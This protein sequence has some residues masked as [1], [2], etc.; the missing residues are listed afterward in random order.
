MAL[1]VLQATGA[2]WLLSSRST[3]CTRATQVPTMQF[4]LL[5]PN[6]WTAP[7][8]SKSLHSLHPARHDELLRVR[9]INRDGATREYEITPTRLSQEFGLQPRYLRNLRSP[10]QQFSSIVVKPDF[11]LF[12]LE[13][14]KGY[15]SNERLILLEDGHPAIKVVERSVVDILQSQQVLE[16][17]QGIGG[18]FELAVL[19]AVLDETCGFFEQSWLRW[20]R[21][22]SQELEHMHHMEDKGVEHSRSDILARLLP[23]EN[24][25]RKLRIRAQRVNDILKSLI[26]NDEDLEMLCLSLQQ[27]HNSRGDGN[28]LVINH[29]EVELLLENFSSRLDNLDDQLG[30]LS[31]RIASS[32]ELLNLSLANERNQILRLELRMAMASLSFAL[33]GAVA[34]FWGMNLDTGLEATAGLAWGVMG[35]TTLAAGS[36]FW[37]LSGAA[38]RVKRTQ[39]RK[40]VKQEALKHV[41]SHMDHIHYALRSDPTLIQRWL[42]NPKICEEDITKMLT[43]SKVIDGSEAEAAKVLLETLDTSRDGVLQLQELK[44]V[45]GSR[46]IC[47]CGLSRQ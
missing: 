33:C 31:G 6:S 26:S 46:G 28:T 30:D 11:F 2:R 35:S 36:L 27:T 15:C 9:E 4:A 3:V 1:R 29:D 12:R 37:V 44:M 23:L 20:N 18:T 41:L 13:L 21:M 47:S 34:G 8:A 24:Q 40:L 17:Q 43:L 38:R 14:F 25:V 19:E 32:R 5:G 39:T 7:A 22:I 16:R 45:A 42:D 10:G